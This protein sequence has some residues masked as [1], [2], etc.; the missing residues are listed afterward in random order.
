MRGNAI[1]DHICGVVPGG[2]SLVTVGM[3]GVTNTSQFK[4]RSSLMCALLHSV[5]SLLPLFPR[6]PLADIGW[7]ME[8]CSSCLLTRAQEAHHLDIH[9]RHLVQVQHRLGA[10]ALQLCLHGLQMLR[11]Q[12]AD[13]PERRV[14][15]VSMPFNLACHLRC[16]FPGL[17]AVCDR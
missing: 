14:V 12:V 16:L 7:A 6:D 9:Q 10:V 17:C 13:Q 3:P 1:G 4:S 11:L 2:R 15:S 8:E 5:C